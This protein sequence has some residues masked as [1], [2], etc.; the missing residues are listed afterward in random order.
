M[1]ETEEELRFPE[2]LLTT[3]GRHQF[4]IIENRDISDD[5]DLQRAPSV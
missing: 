3:V 2:H 5:K 4:H 1:S